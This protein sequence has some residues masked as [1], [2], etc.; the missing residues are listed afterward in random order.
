MASQKP[1][2]TQ[3]FVQHALLFSQEPN[4]V[5]VPSFDPAEQRRDEEVRRIT[6]HGGSL[7]DHVSDP[8]WPT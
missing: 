3:L 6:D 5:A 1:S 2:P 7:G 4:H 8:I